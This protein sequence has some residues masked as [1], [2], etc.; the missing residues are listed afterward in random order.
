MLDLPENPRLIMPRRWTLSPNARR[1]PRRSCRRAGGD[2]DQFRVGG[3]SAMSSNCARPPRHRA[4]IADDRWLVLA[5]LKVAHHSIV[6]ANQLGPIGE[7]LTEID[8][9]DP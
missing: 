6:I 3:S 1:P 9:R 8:P 7:Q 4:P 2:Q 5:L